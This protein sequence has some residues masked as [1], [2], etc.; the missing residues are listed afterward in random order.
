LF[1]ALVATGSDPVIA[2]P[3]QRRVVVPLETLTDS[4]WSEKTSRATIGNH[5][6]T[7]HFKSTP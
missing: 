3:A 4:G 6:E 7:I 5:H 1:S 2:K